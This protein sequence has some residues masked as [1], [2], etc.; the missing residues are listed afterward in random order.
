MTTT[1]L[2]PIRPPDIRAIRAIR[3][4][5]RARSPSEDE[6]T[7]ICKRSEALARAAWAGKGAIFEQ[8]VR[9]LSLS[10][11]LTRLDR[12]PA[13]AAII[14]RPTP[15]VFEVPLGPTDPLPWAAPTPARPP[16]V[17]AEACKIANARAEPLPLPRAKRG[18]KV[19]SLLFVMSIGLGFGLGADASARASIETPLRS[20]AQ[21]AFA[22]VH[23]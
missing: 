18:F 17:A 20:A 15:N 14:V 9:D 1:C 4:R 10:L 8:M 13:P 23:R 21:A 2:P 7:L 16:P 19:P 5:M 11:P 6:E 12:K 3:N 22:L